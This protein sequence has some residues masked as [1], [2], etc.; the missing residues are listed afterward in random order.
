VSIDVAQAFIDLFTD[1]EGA[2]A[3][4]PMYTLL[5]ISDSC[6]FFSEKGSRDFFTAENFALLLQVIDALFM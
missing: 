1:C 4:V 2:G 5:K 6:F 3:S